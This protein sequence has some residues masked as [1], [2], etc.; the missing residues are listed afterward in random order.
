MKISV[1][2]SNYNHAHFLP[3]ALQ[4]LLSQSYPPSEILI[5]DDA[6]TDASVSVIEGFSR[7]YPTIRLIRNDRNIGA[8]QNTNRMFE[9]ASGDY[10]YS[11]AA[12]DKVLPGFFEKT[13]TMLARYPGAA[14]CCSDPAT[15]D[16]KT[17]EILDNRL[18]LTDKP[19]YLSPFEVEQK[20]R[21][22]FFSIAGHT[23]VMKKTTLL[24]A[25]GLLGDLRWHSDWFLLLVMAFRCGI[26][27]VPE[28]LA[29]I[30]VMPESYAAA[31]TKQWPLQ[32]AVLVRM[33]DLLRTDDYR[34]VLPGFRNSSAF[35]EFGVQML[36]VISAHPEH[37][38]FMTPLLVRRALWKASFKAASKL[39]PPALKKIVRKMR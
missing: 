10:I 34:D 8:V 11:A 14:F 31:G 28:P 17:K 24:N 33:L 19:V 22:H 1:T 16:G 35:A 25:G 3:E 4:A 36:R 38:D 39:T 30:R 9:L 29:T 6:S 32:R 2:L 20:M 15:F 12:D 27:Y 23:S 5:T 18:R 13:A 7:K 21:E 37:R 26:C